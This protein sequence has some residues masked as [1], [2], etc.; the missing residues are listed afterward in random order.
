MVLI[1]LCGW[2]RIFAYRTTAV[3]YSGWF[4]ALLEG[5]W[6]RREIQKLKVRE[7]PWRWGLTLV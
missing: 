4:W 3:F 5:D 1:R 7:S 2:E 6:I